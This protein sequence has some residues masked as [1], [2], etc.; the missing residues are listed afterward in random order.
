MRHHVQQPRA[1]LHKHESV[2][3]NHMHGQE[4]TC[5]TLAQSLAPCTAA[6][7]CCKP[8]QGFLRCL[9]SHACHKCARAHVHRIPRNALMSG[10][11]DA[12]ILRL[13]P[14]MCKAC[15]R[16]FATSY[17]PYARKRPHATPPRL[18]AMPL[19][20][21]NA[22]NPPAGALLFPRVQPNPSNIHCCSIH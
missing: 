20:T 1:H 12:C 3:Q 4:Y 19:P 9:H 2:L 14:Q 5:H 17:G 8:A 21:H 7:P 16:A 13:A 15:A 22:P 11:S 10:Q 18:P 6:R